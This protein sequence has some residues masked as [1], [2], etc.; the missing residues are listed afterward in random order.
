MRLQRML[1]PI[2]FILCLLFW[3][4]LVHAD[5]QAGKDAY[6][7]GDYATALKEMR[8]LADQGYAKAQVN[9]GVL[10]ERGQGVPHL[11]VFGK[12]SKIRFLPAHPVAERL[13]VEYLEEAG[14]G[15]DADG[16]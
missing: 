6:D 7:Q 13:I 10:Y 8:P 15:I 14:H 4:A 11:R 1:I 5:F 12:G 16:P 2:V 9:L 3:P